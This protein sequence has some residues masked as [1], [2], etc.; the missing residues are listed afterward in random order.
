V[1]VRLAAS[2]VALW[3]I[4]ALSACSPRLDWREVRGAADGYVVAMPDRPQQVTRELDYTPPS[5]PPA[6]ASAPSRVTMS[7]MSTGV[8]PTMFAVG[9]VRM[10]PDYLSDPR[11]AAAAVDWL[12]AGLAR[13]VGATEPIVT[14][15]PAE[16]LPRGHARRIRQGMEIRARGTVPGPAKAGVETRAA[17]LAARIYVADDRLYQ[18]V[19]LGAEGEIPPEAAENFFSS[20]RLID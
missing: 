17:Q 15:L 14:A 13:N 18:L 11:G 5:V 20:F 16:R 19:V 2:A 3:A 10:P 7:M 9:A 12:R 4:L 1:R 6:G 8:G